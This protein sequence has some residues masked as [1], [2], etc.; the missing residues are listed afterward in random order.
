MLPLNVNNTKTNWFPPPTKLRCYI[1]WLF[2]C[3]FFFAGCRNFLRRF[4]VAPSSLGSFCHLND[5]GTHSFLEWHRAR[6]C[7]KLTGGNR[8]LQQ[9]WRRP[10]VDVTD[11]RQ[12]TYTTNHTHTQVSARQSVS[13][14]S[15]IIG[16]SRPSCWQG[17]SLL[18]QDRGKAQSAEA[19]RAKSGWGRA[20]SSLSGVLGRVFLKVFLHSRGAS[21]RASPGTSWGGRQ[22]WGGNGPPVPLLKSAY[23]QNTAGLVI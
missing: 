15:R 19:Q 13:I 2:S 5:D 1:H 21:H 23:V 20:V 7:R 8:V 11:G 4:L 22:V 16:R 9:F 10:A 6:G 17:P 14:I 12:R 3:S 18:L